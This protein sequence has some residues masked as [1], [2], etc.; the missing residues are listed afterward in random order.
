VKTIGKCPDPPNQN[1]TQPEITQQPAVNASPGGI[2]SAYLEPIGASP[3]H[4]AVNTGATY[5]YGIARHKDQYPGSTFT[6]ES[7]GSAFFSF[8]AR[9]RLP[10]S[11]PST[12]DTTYVEGESLGLKYVKTV[13]ATLRKLH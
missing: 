5:Q 11:N 3:T 9:F 8:T 13:H 7:L 2:A 1:W 6:N 12:F 10:L 4:L